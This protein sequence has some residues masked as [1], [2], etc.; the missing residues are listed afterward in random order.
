[1]TLWYDRWQSPIGVLHMVG[2]A[3]HLR[4]L[5]YD[6]NWPRLKER[7]G[8]MGERGPMSERETAL[9]ALL[10]REL[11]E[12]FAGRR[13][14]FTVPLR[15]Q[16]T[17]F[18]QR[19]WDALGAIPY[20]A[21]ATYRDQAQTIGQPAAV[22]AVGHANGQNPISILVPCHRVIA[23]SGALAGYAGGLPAKEFLLRLERT[24]HHEGMMK[25]TAA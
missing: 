16:G 11:G 14:S 6:A 2:D 23:S 5:A 10:K 18:Q 3:T 12:Y 17:V 1:M 15:P 22:R 8:P 21:T 7:L 20:G 24:A 25:D 19:V 4:V 9:S 13:R